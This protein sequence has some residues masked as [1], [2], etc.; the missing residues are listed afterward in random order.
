VISISGNGKPEKC[1]GRIALQQGALGLVTDFSA[2]FELALVSATIF[3]N[4]SI[5][6]F[7][8]NSFENET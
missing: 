8:R 1:S 4:N 7:G 3:D 5:W 2:F 6:D